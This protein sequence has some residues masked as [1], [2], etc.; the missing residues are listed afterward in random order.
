MK[1]IFFLFLISLSLGLL[2]NTNANANEEG[3]GFPGEK[4]PT[5]TRP[6]SFSSIGASTIQWN[7]SLTLQQQINRDSDYANY[8]GLSVN[9][10]REKNYINWGWSIGF[11]VGAGRAV[12]GGNSTIV[13]YKK[14]QVDFVIYGISPRIFYRFSERASAGISPHVFMKNIDWPK[15]EN[16]ITVDAGR[17]INIA[18][19]ADLNLRL[20]QKW[21]F[22]TGI[23]PLTEG[24]TFWRIGTNYRF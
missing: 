7:E 11:F 18:S 8:S 13:N 2:V 15:D 23:G 12:G 10:Q 9:L 5:R 22:Y 3:E 16:N 20:F 21:D 19:L 1:K 17:K 14:D 24:S 6:T 4:Q